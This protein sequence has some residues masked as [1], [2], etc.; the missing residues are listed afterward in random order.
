MT[1]RYTSAN[2]R[3]SE[4]LE[5][6]RE[7][8][9]QLVTEEWDTYQDLNWNRSRQFEV[10][11]LFAQVRPERVL[12]IGCGC[13]YH[14]LLMA[15]KPG[16]K[17]VLGIDYSEKSIETANRIYPHPAV[18]RQV[19]DIFSF[20][21]NGFDLA[22]SFQV[23][24][25]LI[26]AQTFLATNRELVRPGGWV[27]AVTPNRQRALNRIF[28]LMGRPIRLSDPQ[29]FREYTV[30]ELRELGARVGLKFQGSF[31]YGMSI[32]IPLLRRSLIFAPWALRL[33]YGVPSLA[34]CICAIFRR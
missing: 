24:E 1:D 14:D 22:V 32:P 13:G 34:D 19:A 17:N 23:I 11:R 29:H 3:Q 28:A 6:Q 12:D 20:E 15:V 10:D 18:K 25:H 21:Q 31:G 5:D 4:F 8:F 33:G 2:S 27:A 26:D 30:D 16:V 7:I 9:D